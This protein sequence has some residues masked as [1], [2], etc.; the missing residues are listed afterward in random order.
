MS[1]YIQY[2]K[3]RWTALVEAGIEW[4][5]PLADLDAAGARAKLVE[6][7]RL[8][9]LGVSD[10]TD[11]NVLCLASGGGQQSVMFSLLGA[12]VTVLD[13]ADAQ[14][15]K[16]RAMAVQYGY[17]VRLIQGNMT[18]LSMLADGSF[19]LVW[20]PY[21]INFVPDPLPV[22]AEVGRI[23]R[24]GG[25]YY[26][27]FCNPSWTMEESDWTEMGYPM[28]VPIEQGREMSH[29]DPHWDIVDGEG[30]PQRV[31]G[32]REWMHTYATL[33]NGLGRNGMQVYAMYEGPPGDI[34]AET[35]TWEHIKAWMPLWPAFF[36]IK[37]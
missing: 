35:G 5:R 26:L 28:R 18:D 37:N 21:S 24:A 25:R 8:E 23:L 30:K 32:P 15:E 22:L 6:G 11:L 1:E 12:N 19:D 27:Q 16:D 9:M 31:L 2:N 4:S 13:F 17:D 33:I 20:Q 36:S 10:F 14:L 34:S 3:E 29:L 7:N